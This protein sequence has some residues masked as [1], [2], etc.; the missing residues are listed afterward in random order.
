MK[1]YVGIK[2]CSSFSKELK[3]LLNVEINPKNYI[4]EI[5]S[6]GLDRPL[7]SL[8]DFKRFTGR[9]AKVRIE[10]EDGRNYV[11]VGK[12]NSCDEEK[13]AFS[14]DVGGKI[15]I[16]KFSEVASANLEVEF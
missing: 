13:G 14:L 12:I 16:H 6:P 5:S 15:Q 1:D 9:L 3:P 7:R 11:F 4:L 2:D 10:G 8:K